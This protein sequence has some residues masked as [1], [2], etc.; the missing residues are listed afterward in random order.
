VGVAPSKPIKQAEL[1]ASLGAGALGAGLALIAPEWLRSWALP[2]L[3]VGLVAHG[4]GMTL[5]YRLQARQSPPLWWERCVFAM[6]WLG[7]AALAW[8]LMWALLVRG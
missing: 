7:L 4:A 6:C 5:K 3:A 2:V 1:V 8:A